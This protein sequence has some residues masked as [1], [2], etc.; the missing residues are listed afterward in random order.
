[1]LRSMLRWAAFGSLRPRVT[2]SPLRRNM[3]RAVDSSSAPVRG[4]GYTVLGAIAVR[5]LLSGRDS[6]PLSQKLKPGESMFIETRRP[7]RHR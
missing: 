6:E 1:M 7:E 3:M 5:R 2:A 4:F